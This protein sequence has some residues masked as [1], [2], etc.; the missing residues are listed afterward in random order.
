M[1]LADYEGFQFQKDDRYTL[2]Y[3]VFERFLTMK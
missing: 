2:E 3:R 1:E